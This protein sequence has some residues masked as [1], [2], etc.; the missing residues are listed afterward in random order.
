MKRASQPA[1][2]LAYLEQH[3]SITRLEAFNE[4][5]IANL[6]CRVSDLERLGHF[7]ERE[8]VKVPNRLG[9]TVTVTEYTL[10]RVAYG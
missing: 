3:N 1:R 5:G 10:T 6:W 2:L 8:D 7:I 4:L 9:Q